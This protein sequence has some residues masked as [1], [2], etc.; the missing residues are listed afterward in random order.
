MNLGLST[1]CAGL[2][3]RARGEAVVGIC[4]NAAP[5]SNFASCH[6]AVWG[7]GVD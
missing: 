4:M 6:W 7:E 3:T 2:K 1:M 5:F